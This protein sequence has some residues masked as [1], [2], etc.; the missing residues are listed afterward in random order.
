MPRTT[1]RLWPIAVIVL[2]SGCP[3]YGTI[4]PQ[5][6]RVGDTTGALPPRA[7]TCLVG[8]VW[9]AG[10]IAAPVS[11][12]TL[13]LSREGSNPVEGV[14]STTG[15]YRLCPDWTVAPGDASTLTGSLAVSAPG[16]ASTTQVVALADGRDAS[17]DVML[18]ASTP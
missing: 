7:P 4:G 11:G 1:H 15:A 12:A 9:R 3:L 14:T 10:S 2:A 6:V 16:L 5:G 13:R 8:S 18:V 17:L